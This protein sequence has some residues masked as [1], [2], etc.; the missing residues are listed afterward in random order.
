[1]SKVIITVEGDTG[2]G[3]STIAQQ[4]ANHFKTI[5]FEATLN[6]PGATRTQQCHL[7]AIHSLR[8][9]GLEIEINEKQLPRE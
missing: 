9:N 2:A 3:T 4:I 1:M 8:E 7:K 6:N 5:E